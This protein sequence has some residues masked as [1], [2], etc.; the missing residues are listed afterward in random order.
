MIIMNDIMNMRNIP[1]RIKEEGMTEISEH[2][3]AKRERKKMKDTE[4]EREGT[5][6]KR[7]RRKK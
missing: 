6:R 7:R 3:K 5:R 4:W 2:K 1:L